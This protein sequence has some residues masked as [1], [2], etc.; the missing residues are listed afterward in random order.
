MGS[1]FQ[2][3]HQNFPFHLPQILCFFLVPSLRVSCSTSSLIKIFLKKKKEKRKKIDSNAFLV[4][5]NHVIW[6][7]KGKYIYKLIHIKAK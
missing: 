5:K 4:L 1:N 6:K 7:D 2:Q 3:A